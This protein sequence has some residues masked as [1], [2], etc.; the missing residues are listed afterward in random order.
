VLRFRGGEISAT[1]IIN[2]D[3]DLLGATVRH[4]HAHLD[5]HIAAARFEKASGQTKPL[6][7]P[8]D[9]TDSN[10]IPSYMGLE[11]MSP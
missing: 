2:T 6:I 5:V 9:Q 4:L 8:T 10:S 3:L 1:D 7:L 11:S